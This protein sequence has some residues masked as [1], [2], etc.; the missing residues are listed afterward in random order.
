MKRAVKRSN[1]RSNTDANDMILVKKQCSIYMFFKKK[2]TKKFFSP[3]YNKGEGTR[4][5]VKV[6]QKVLD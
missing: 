1:Q 2:G 5:L 3:L 6:T 4:L